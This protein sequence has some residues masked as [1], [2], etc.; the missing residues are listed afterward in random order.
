MSD[1]FINQMKKQIEAELSGYLRDEGIHFSIAAN[2][3]VPDILPC[4]TLDSIDDQPLD[5]HHLLT[6]IRLVMGVLGKPWQCESLVQGLYQILQPHHVS[7][8]ELTV[9][10]MSLHVETT[11]WSNPDYLKQ[12][13]VMRYVVEVM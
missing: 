1:I 4:V 8:P 3:N 11:Q 13:T 2:D 12:K 7:L 6:E 10:L 5:K 9:L